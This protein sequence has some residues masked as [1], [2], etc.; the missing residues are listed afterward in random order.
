MEQHKRLPHWQ[1]P[2]ATYFVTWRL[3]GSLPKEKIAKTWTNDEKGYIAHDDLIEASRTGPKW[4]AEPKIAEAVINVLL[5]GE[6]R[7]LYEL[8]AWVLMPN[9]IHILIRRHLSGIPHV[10]DSIRRGLDQ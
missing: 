1:K 4:L 6:K 5:E 3:H 9:H 8:G 2:G 10:G 7:N